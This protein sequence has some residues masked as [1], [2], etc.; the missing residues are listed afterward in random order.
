MRL[1]R[2]IENTGLLMM[3]AGCPTAISFEMAQHLHAWSSPRRIAYTA[4]WL[5][6]GTLTIPL[7]LSGRITLYI[8][9]RIDT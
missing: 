4:F 6:L 5:G 8:T 3:A 7:Y 2:T 1:K 9:D